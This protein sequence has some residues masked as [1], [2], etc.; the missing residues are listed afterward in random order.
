MFFFFSFRFSFSKQRKKKERK[1]DEE[2]NAYEESFNKEVNGILRTDRLLEE[3]CPASRT[4]FSAFYLHY[5]WRVV[6]HS[7]SKF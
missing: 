1:R 7:P 3:D 4:F 2:I 6:N 5:T